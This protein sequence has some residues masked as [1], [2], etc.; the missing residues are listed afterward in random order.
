MSCLFRAGFRLRGCLAMQGGTKRS[1]VF[2]GSCAA[3]ECEEVGSRA[4]QPPTGTTADTS[5][6]GAPPVEDTYAF[7][8]GDARSRA[9][10]LRRFSGLVGCLAVRSATGCSTASSIDESYRGGFRGKDARWN[11]DVLRL[12]ELVPGL[13]GWVH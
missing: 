5:R 7:G 9:P 13:P 4:S 12:Q 10:S 1:S 2:R 11:A 6:P 8:L 3:I